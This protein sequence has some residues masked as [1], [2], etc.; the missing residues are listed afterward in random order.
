MYG[1]LNPQILL[2][3]VHRTVVNSFMDTINLKVSVL[4]GIWNLN[5]SAIEGLKARYSDK[6]RDCSDDKKNPTLF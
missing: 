1:T 4:G 6:N 3:S 2:I 5:R